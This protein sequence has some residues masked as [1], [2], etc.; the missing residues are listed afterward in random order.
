MTDVVL[1]A[2]ALAEYLVAS[3]R[4]REIADIFSS[5]D[6][7]PVHV[8]HLCIVEAMSALQ[9][10]VRRG[11]LPVARA[12]GAIEDLHAFPARRWDAEPF[13]DRIWELRDHITAYDATYVALAEEL[14][15]LL[16]T[17]NGRLAR[18]AHDHSD[19]RVRL[20]PL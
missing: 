15:A 12:A 4:G 16:V 17:A 8:P 1:D 14:D 5:S 2:S 9:S 13:L 3:P 18:A 20:V 7:P 11:E 6:H 19:C 10:W